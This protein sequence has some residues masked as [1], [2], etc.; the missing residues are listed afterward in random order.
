MIQLDFSAISGSY[1]EKSMIQKSASE[2]LIDLLDIRGYEKI[3]DVGCGTG[4]LTSRL[5]KLT[6]NNITGTDPSEG[7][8]QEAKKQNKFKRLQFRQ[9]S[10]EELDY[11]KEFDIIFCNSALQWIKDIDKVLDNFYTALKAGGKVG[12]QAPARNIYSPNF[13]KAIDKV[14]K[15]KRTIDVF[16][17]FQNP[18]L[19]YDSPEEYR[20]V[21]ERHR[22]NVDYCNINTIKSLY[23][24][25]EVFKI[26]SS[27]AAAGYLNSDYYPVPVTD[28]YINSFNS[29]VMEEFVD[30]GNK[31][32]LVELEFNRIYLIATR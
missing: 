32:G 4:K 30:Q 10:A 9:V 15:N 20:S 23:S 27:G 16:A 11:N 1:S 24:P 26:F 22:F 31:N 19:F 21:F 3:L 17:K 29:I 18:W 8:I 13:I 28:D 14:K 6:R 12:I 2:I 7:M 5:L 25:E